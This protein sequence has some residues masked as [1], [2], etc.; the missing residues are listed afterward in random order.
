MSQLKKTARQPRKMGSWTEET[1]RLAIK[2]VKKG[3]E[4]MRKIGEKYNI[5]ASSIRDWISGKTSS[6]KKGPRTVLSQEEENDIVNWCLQTQQTSHGITFYMLRKKVADVCQGRET[7]F[8]DGVPGKR[9]LE[10]FKK[11]HPCVSIEP[12]H[13]LKGKKRPESEREVLAGKKKKLLGP[14]MSLPM[15]LPMTLPMTHPMTV[16]LAERDGFAMVVRDPYGGQSEVPAL[17]MQESQDML[18]LAHIRSAGDMGMMAVN[19]GM[20]MSMGMGIGI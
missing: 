13:A 12:A 17:N 15:M 11:R 7:P 9:W 16:P 10:W 8:K 19:D 3:N 14:P 5:P 2:E 18:T 1:M 6:K 4:S 20:G